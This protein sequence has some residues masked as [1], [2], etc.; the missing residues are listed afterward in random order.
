[1]ITQKQSTVRSNSVRSQESALPH[2]S[3]SGVQSQELK[4]RTP[5]SLL[6]TILFF[7]LLLAVFSLGLYL[8]GKCIYNKYLREVQELRMEMRENPN[9]VVIVPHNVGEKIGYQMQKKDL[10]LQLSSEQLS[11]EQYSELRTTN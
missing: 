10:A 5:N 7:G 8:G 2:S 9:S 3:E 11:S 6:R 4:L 1:M